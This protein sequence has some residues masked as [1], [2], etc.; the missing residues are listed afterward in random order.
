MDN[1]IIDFLREVTKDLEHAGWNIR[2]GGDPDDFMDSDLADAI[3]K[4]AH[5]LLNGAEWKKQ[6]IETLKHE[7]ELLKYE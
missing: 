2:D 4:H 5:I 3:K 7:L 1:P 6:R